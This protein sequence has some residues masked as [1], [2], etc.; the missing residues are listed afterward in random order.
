MQFIIHRSLIIVNL[1]GIVKDL[2]LH[3]QS[4][5]SKFLTVPGT[6]VIVEKKKVSPNDNAEHQVII[7][8]LVLSH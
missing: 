3:L 1:S 8:N 6:Y 2:P 7:Y 4:C 5:A